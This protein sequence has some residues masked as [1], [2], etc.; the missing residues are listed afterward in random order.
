MDAFSSLGFTEANRSLQI[1]TPEG[2]DAFLTE[3]FW[4]HQVVN[5]MDEAKVTVRAKRDDVKPQDMVG[6]EVTVSLMADHSGARRK[7]K[8]FVKISPSLAGSTKK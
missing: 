6:K 1:D 7:W 2:K 8:S 3:R 5:G 4:C